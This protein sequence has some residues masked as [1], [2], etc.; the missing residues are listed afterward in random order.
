MGEAL[1]RFRIGVSSLE[2]ALDAA[3]NWRSTARLRA[4]DAAV[5]RLTEHFRRERSALKVGTI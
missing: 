4:W 1:R 3:P 5:V 2:H